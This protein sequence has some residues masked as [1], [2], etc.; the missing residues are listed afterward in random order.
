MARKLVYAV[1]LL[2]L[3]LLPANPGSAA[4]NSAASGNLQQVLAQLDKSARNFHSA[5]A[6]FEFKNIQTEP[7]PDTDV[8]TGT[9]YYQH[10][11]SGLRVAAHIDRQNGQPYGSVYTYTNGVFQLYDPRM[12]QVTKLQNSTNLAGYVAL[13]F[14]ATGQDLQKEFQITYLGQETIDGVKTAKLELIFKNPKARATIPKV[15]MWIDPIRDVSLKQVFD[16][17]Q[18]LSRVATYSHIEMNH[19]ISSSEFTFKTNKQTQFT[20]Q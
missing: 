20:T 1:P 18:G 5:S 6:D 13:G 19:S 15:T 14:G 17:G 16:E 2:F 12:N 11:G 8:M 9:V 4:Q 3:L 7:V 10:Q